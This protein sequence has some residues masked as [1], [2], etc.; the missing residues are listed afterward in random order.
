[1]ANLEHIAKFVVGVDAWNEWRDT[2]AGSRPDLSDIDFFNVGGQPA[3]CFP[4]YSGF[5]FSHCNLNRASLRNCVFTE[6][7]FSGSALHF[8]DLVDSH[9]TNCNFQDAGLNVSKIGSAEFIS[10]DFTDAELSYCTAEDTSFNGSIFIRTKLDNMSLVKTDFS[11]TTIDGALVYGTSAW[12][13]KLD[14]SLQ[15]N[16]YISDQSSTITVPNIELAQFIAL[17]VTNSKI[18]E[19]IDTITSKVV[20]ILGRFTEPRKAVLDAIKNELQVHGY[21][22]VLFD[23]EGPQNRD[24]T[25]TIVTLASMSKFVVADLSMAKSVPQELSSVVPHFPSI[26]VQPIIHRQEQEY[27]MFEHFKKYPWVMKLLLYSDDEVPNLVRDI[28][29]NCEGHFTTETYRAH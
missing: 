7:D 25:E 18:R 9:C 2:A 17:L 13:L 15:Q 12:D 3:F 24:I 27:A 4:E 11:N 26:P 23:F 5:N 1:M 22:P 16:I 28:V 10:C 21:L 8:S 6:C 14:G 20:L 19:I 29:K